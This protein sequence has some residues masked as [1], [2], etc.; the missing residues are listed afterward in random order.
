MKG[1]FS[2]DI[3]WRRSDGVERGQVIARSKLERIAGIISGTSDELST[4]MTVRGT[5]V[6]ID[7][8]TKTFHFVV[9]DGE[10]YRGRLAEDFPLS[11]QNQVPA[12]YSAEIVTLE[13]QHYATD[14]KETRHVLRSL[15]PVAGVGGQQA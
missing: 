13:K 7:V 12:V 15:T 2:A 14:Q 9:T 10:S 4:P 8:T 3:R 1:G 11:R 6:G 5:L